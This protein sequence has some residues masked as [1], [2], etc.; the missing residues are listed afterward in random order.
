MVNAAASNL[1][2]TIRLQYQIDSLAACSPARLNQVNFFNRAHAVETGRFWQNAAP[3]IDSLT[4]EP[5][6]AGTGE[7]AF[8]RRGRYPE[9]G[10][11]AV[12]HLNP[13]WDEP[14]GCSLSC[15]NRSEAL[16]G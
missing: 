2:T 10:L 9:R 8:A 1:A 14:A 12:A 16:S 11:D 15:S 13:G 5:A 7:P 6:L 4:L 3:V